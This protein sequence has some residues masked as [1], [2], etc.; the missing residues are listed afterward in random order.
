MEPSEVDRYRIKV[1][2][3]RAHQQIHRLN[4]I[5]K[6]FILPVLHV[7]S[8]PRRVSGSLDG[9]FR[10]ILSLKTREA[11]AVRARS[12]QICRKVQGIGG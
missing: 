2:T 12:A 11:E 7:R 10:G 6:S 4:H 5:H 1:L 9:D 3:S 8:P